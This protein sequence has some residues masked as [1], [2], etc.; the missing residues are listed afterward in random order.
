MQ[1]E[2]NKPGGFISKV[3]HRVKGGAEPSVPAESDRD[4]NRQMLSLM[5]ERRR[6]ND[7]IRVQEFAQLRQL[8]RQ[9]RARAAAQPPASSGFL[10]SI[11]DSEVRAASTLKKIDAIEAQMSQQWWRPEPESALPA[12]GADG[13][14]EAAEAL[15]AVAAVAVPEASEFPHGLTA[16]QWQAI[17]TLGAE[18]MVAPAL[19]LWGE[20]AVIASPEL[21]EAAIL[22]ANGDLDSAKAR[23]L[24]LLVQGL[25]A[26]PLDNRMVAGVWHAVLDLYRATGDE[27]GFE[28]L[29]IDYA[30]HFGRS[31]PLWFSMPAQLGLVPLRDP[32]AQPPARPPFHWNAP[33]T[34][35]VDAVLALDAEQQAAA[36]PWRLD[37]SA[38]RSVEAAAI[39]VL[40]RLLMRWSG[41]PGEWLWGGMY[42]LRELLRR[43]T[44]TG[45]RSQSPQWWALHMAV[46]R[47]LND[48]QVFDQV[49]LDYCVTFEVSPPAWEPPQCQ[50]LASDAADA[51][52]A[53]DSTLAETGAASAVQH[54]APGA[55]QGLAGVVEGDARP[56]LEPLQARA[57]LGVPLEIPC[58]L[59]IR[60]DFVAAG[61]VLNWAA[62]MQG[63]GHQLHFTQLH[64][65]VAVLLQV[66]GLPA[67]A[68]LGLRTV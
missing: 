13:A 33:D 8:R 42:A 3:L 22:F 47:M 37:W 40:G 21:E 62:E 29:A 17:P 46:Q 11:L 27:E 15:A 41:Q 24:Q 18:N 5:V 6:H 65:L 50:C 26:E 53:L 35:T 19:V 68:R 31:A 61:T 25:E 4:D 32:A 12:D 64:H 60:L 49:A 44:P 52:Q 43:Q 45:D 7:V 59:L 34:L 10:P 14:A 16:A 54:A 20:N 58:D 51:L 9:G 63:Q 2:P 48:P 30:A 28:P 38:L 57:R 55:W 66:I 36:S 1:Q 39:P 56:W 67:H 23:L